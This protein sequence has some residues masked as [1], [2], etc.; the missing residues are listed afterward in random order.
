MN[1]E[2]IKVGETYN[3]R[4]T[5]EE[6]KD[7]SWLQ[8]RTGKHAF[9]LILGASEAEAFSPISPANG[10]KNTEPAPKYDP[11]RKFLWGDKV[12]VK[13]EVHGRSVYI[14]ED[15]WEPLDPTEIWEVV[16]EKETGWVHLKN[17]CLTADVWHGMLELVTPVGVI[18]PYFI[19]EG[20]GIIELYNRTP[21]EVVKTWYYDAVKAGVEALAEAEAECARLNVEYRKEQ[22]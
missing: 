17:G 9:A 20:A 4:V 2:D 5:V 16:E 7:T 14:G 11:C 10:I 18:E 19:S 21:D 13:R 3:V 22:E 15:A 12:R 1:I 6:K 8:V